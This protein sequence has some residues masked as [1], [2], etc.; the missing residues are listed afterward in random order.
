MSVK[1]YLLKF[2][3]LARYAPNVVFDDGSRM[4]KFV[5]SVVD[6]VVKKCRTTMLIKEID[7]SRLMAHSQQVEE[8]KAK[9]KERENKRARTCSFN[10]AQPRSGSGN[11]PQFLQ[12]S[13]SPAPS[14]ASALV[15]KFRNDNRDRPPGSKPQ[16][17]VNNGRT[18]PLCQKYG[19]N[20]QGV[21][22]AGSDVYFR[23]GMPGHRVMDC[24]K[25]GQQG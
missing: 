14:S 11:R 1:Q 8:Q 13:S 10:F 16:D 22:R 7:F 4:S 9:E 2:T 17:S 6:G 25:S 21:C 15:P 3:Q 20:H 18:N 23:C 5:S 24:L 12:K 19:K